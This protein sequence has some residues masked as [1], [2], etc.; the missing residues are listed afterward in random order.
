MTRIDARALS[1]ALGRPEGEDHAGVGADL[2]TFPL[3]LREPELGTRRTPAEEARTIVA[4]TR[5]AG[6]AT[7]SE[8]G[9]P[10]SSVVGFGELPDG[11][12]VLVVSTLAEHGRNLA[13]D[14]RASLSIAAPVPEGVDPLDAGRVTLSGRV[15]VPEGAAAEQALVAH[16]EAY[17]A[18][19]AY[20]QF[21]DFTLYVLRPERVR[22]VGGFGRMDSALG[23]DYA[24][25]EADPVDGARAEA[26]R[27]HLNEDHADALLLMAQEI[28]GYSDATSAYCERL[29]RYGMDLRL[30]T[31]RGTAWARVGW[32]ERAGQ[33]G[34]LRR[35]SVEL[36][37]HAEARR[38]AAR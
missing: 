33:V 6:L 30:R 5:L 21:G 36:V 38:D 26:A 10:W 37:R 3:P 19:R 9:S 27:V 4:S 8:D 25:A 17:P 31:L 12:I 16:C 28:A 14:P 34:D 20:A 2:S 1:A 23:E 22:W 35:L 24:V 29:D 15:Q 11:G 32:R 13:R 7:L 18:A